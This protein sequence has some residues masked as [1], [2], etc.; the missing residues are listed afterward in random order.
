MTWF[1]ALF[2]YTCSREIGKRERKHNDGWLHYCRDPD[3][4][5]EHL[6]AHQRVWIAD[7]FATRF[8]SDPLDVAKRSTIAC[9]SLYSRL[10]R[11]GCPSSTRNHA[12]YAMRAMA[13]DMV[14]MME[15]LGFTH[16]SV[17][18]HDRGGRVAYRMALDYPAR[19]DRLAALDVL[20]TETVWKRI[21][22]RLTLVYWPW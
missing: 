22:A 21:D 9:P 5:D 17:V 12:P 10:R 1:R 8:S 19:V 7:P 18:G 20:P 15:R 16:F 14:I 2:I 13:Q 6:R 3:W 4:R 11:S